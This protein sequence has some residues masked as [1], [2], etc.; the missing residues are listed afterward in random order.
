[1]HQGLSGKIV[2]I[3]GASSGIGEATALAFAAEGAKLVL[4]A[5]DLD[6]VQAVVDR[7]VATGAEALAVQVDVTDAASVKALAER[8]VGFGGGVDVWFSNVGVG[9]VGLFHET[10]IEAHEQVIRAN[11]IGHMNDA[12]AAVPVF[13]Q[14]QRGIFI[15]MISLGGFAAAPWAAAYSASKFGLRGFTEA[16]RGELTRYPD[17]HVCDVYPAF[18]DTP[19]IGHGANYVGK[20]LSAPPPVMDARR[21]AKA[22]VGLARRPRPGLTLGAPAFAVQLM[23]GIAPRSTAAAMDGFMRL[24]TRKGRPDPISDG[25]LFAPPADPGGIDGGLKRVNRKAALAAGIVL[26][27]AAAL[28]I[29]THITRPRR[30]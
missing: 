30:S 24:W 11:L 16:L 5:R 28:M 26:G 1:M 12:H 3:T 14:Q 21:V 23:H 13:L 20:A 29:A 22:V 4:A 2:V 19:G 9:A 18:V 17:I 27:G 7:C 6:A 8:A 10:P 15:N 25:N